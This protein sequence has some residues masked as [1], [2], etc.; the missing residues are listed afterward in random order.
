MQH[1]LEIA[2]FVLSMQLQEPHPEN[3]DAGY[4]HSRVTALLP[5]V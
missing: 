1:T 5:R 4:H 3:E 2:M